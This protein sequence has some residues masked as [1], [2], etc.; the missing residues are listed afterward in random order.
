MAKV[1]D[2]DHQYQDDE[3]YKVDDEDCASGSKHVQDYDGQ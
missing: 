3:W 2:F 1:T